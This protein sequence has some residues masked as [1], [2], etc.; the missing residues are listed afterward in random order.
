MGFVGSWYCNWV[1]NSVRKEF[2]FESELLG[3]VVLLDVVELF[4]A[5]ELARL[6][7]CVVV[8]PVSKGL[9]AVIGTLRRCHG[10]RCA[11]LVD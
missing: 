1:K 7:A 3:A 11:C 2:M 10:C 6:C 5:A 9:G 4:D 8:L